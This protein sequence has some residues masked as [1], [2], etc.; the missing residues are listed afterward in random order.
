MKLKQSWPTLVA[1]VAVAV[2]AAAAVVVAAAAVGTACDFAQAAAAFAL[3]LGPVR[4]CWT[5]TGLSVRMATLHEAGAGAAG[6]AVLVTAA[7]GSFALW[8]RAVLGSAP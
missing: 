4:E 3:L 7:G 6:A 1:A 8:R 2:A 5:G